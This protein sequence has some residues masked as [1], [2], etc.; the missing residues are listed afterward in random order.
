MEDQDNPVN[1]VRR[2]ESHKTN[3]EASQEPEVSMIVE[4]SSH[5]ENDQVVNEDSQREAIVEIKG[6]DSGK[7]KIHYIRTSNLRV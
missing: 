6:C 7:N 4:D 1:D 2:E 5:R 3:V